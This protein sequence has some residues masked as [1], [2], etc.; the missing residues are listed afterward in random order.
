MMMQQNA[1]TVRNPEWLRKWREGT[2][3]A[4]GAIIPLKPKPDESEE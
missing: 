3:R 2:A 4:A 1:D